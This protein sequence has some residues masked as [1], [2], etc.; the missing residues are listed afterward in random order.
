MNT[1]TT[2]QGRALATRSLVRRAWVSDPMLRIGCVPIDAAAW[3]LLRLGDVA[4]WLD[5][6]RRSLDG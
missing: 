3:A 4:S 2:G 1:T 5:R 6:A